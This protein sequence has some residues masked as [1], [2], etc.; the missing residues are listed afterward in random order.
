MAY[1]DFPEDLQECHRIEKLLSEVYSQDYFNLDLE[2]QYWNAYMTPSVHQHLPEMVEEFRD[3]ANQKRNPYLSLELIHEEFAEVLSSNNHEDHL[4]ELADLLYVCYG[5]ANSLSFFL[6]VD[7]SKPC[8]WDSVWGRWQEFDQENDT[9][10]KLYNL[11]NFVQSVYGYCLY[12]GYNINEAVKRVHENNIGRMTQED[13]SIIYRADGKV[14]K[15]PNYPK[16]DLSD[17]V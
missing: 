17:L 12:K 5:Y 8:T 6:L 10:L 7:P 15:N 9:F 13:G 16:V 3:K 1:L 14:V 2:K 11:G 4:K